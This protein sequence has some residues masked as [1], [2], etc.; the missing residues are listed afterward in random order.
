MLAA[1]N[2]PR[3]ADKY[4]R[5]TSFYLAWLWLAVVSDVSVEE[6]RR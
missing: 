4:G 5:K 3:F 6:G 2:Q 1:S